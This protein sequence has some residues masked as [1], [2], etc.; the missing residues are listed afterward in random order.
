MRG[1][2]HSPFSLREKALGENRPLM[3]RLSASTKSEQ[4]L[5]A[6]KTSFCRLRV[7]N[8]AQ[9]KQNNSARQEQYASTHCF[10]LERKLCPKE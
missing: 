10:C 1:I 8:C 7:A 3:R 2:D 6:S 9:V 5:L 4:Q